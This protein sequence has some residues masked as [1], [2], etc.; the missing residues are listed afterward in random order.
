MIAV[1]L[2]SDRIGD[3]LSHFDVEFKM[4]LIITAHTLGVLTNFHVSFCNSYP[5]HVN[6]L[7]CSSLI[8]L[9][10]TSNFFKL[11]WILILIPPSN[12]NRSYNIISIIKTNLVDI[13]I[14]ILKHVKVS[15]NWGIWFNIWKFNAVISLRL[16]SRWNSGHLNFLTNQ[17]L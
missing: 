2:T 12:I 6:L 3:A 14:H 4:L 11:L 9:L 7:N 5:V 1:R 15:I 10:L 17:F 8:L 13:L 16:N